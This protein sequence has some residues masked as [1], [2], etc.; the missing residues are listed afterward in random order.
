[1]KFSV[2]LCTYMRPQS[3][4][5][6]LESLQK[7]SLPANEILI[8]DGSVDTETEKAVE[9][10]TSSSVKYI[11]VAP[12]NRGLTLQRNVGVRLSSDTS[13]VLVFL[14]DDV[15]LDV[16]FLKEIIAPFEQPDIVGVDG[17][18][19]NENRWIKCGSEAE[20][21]GYMYLDGYKLPLSGR[22]KFRLR[23][24][25]F[26]LHVQP[27]NTPV[28]GHGKSTLPPTG[29]LYEVDHLMGCMMAYR[30]SIFTHLAFSDY[31]VG[32]GLY[33]DYDFSLRARAYGKLVTNTA[34]R[35]EHHHAPSGRPNTYKY[36]KMVVRNGWYVWRLRHP[37]PG[38]VNVFKWHTIT[39]LLAFFRLANA[40]STNSETRRQALGDFSGR[41]VGWFT[42]LLIKPKLSH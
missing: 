42:L 30:K 27:G 34:A 35:L 37:Q 10:F 32:Y 38:L 26:P 8:I 14:D 9:A 41:I 2:I 36:G 20:E 18:I 39:L 11:R 3:L 1:M 19:T 29:K 16:H 31:F 21:N 12:E 4:I 28:Y 15:I 13:E 23:L 33:E 7:Q 24:G 22:D 25:L 5:R 6:V 40:L 17:H